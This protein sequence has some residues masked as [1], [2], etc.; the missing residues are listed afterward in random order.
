MQ[1]LDFDS[2][3]QWHSGHFKGV[4]VTRKDPDKIQKGDKVKV[5]L[6]GSSF[7]GVVLVNE[8]SAEICTPGRR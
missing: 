2:L 6:E 3:P 5:I 1:F 4:E 8:N 7:N